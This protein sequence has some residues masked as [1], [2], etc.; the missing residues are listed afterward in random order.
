[1]RNITT[2]AKAVSFEDALRN[3]AAKLTGTDPVTGE[4]QRAWGWDLANF[5]S[6]VPDSLGTFGTKAGITAFKLTMG[7]TVAG[8]TASYVGMGGQTFDE[9]RGDFDQ[10]WTNDEGELD[11]VSGF[12]GVANVGGD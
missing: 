11:L 10:T 7:G 6:I 5:A 2:P 9:T 1:M 4:S 12:A 3:L 8:Q